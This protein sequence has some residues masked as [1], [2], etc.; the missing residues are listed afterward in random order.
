MRLCAAL[1]NAGTISPLVTAI[2]WLSPSKT[3]GRGLE[4]YRKQ[5]ERWLARGQI[6]D[7]GET[8]ALPGLRV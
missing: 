6:Y 1:R 2:V 5:R 4:Q 7:E 8:P 3:D